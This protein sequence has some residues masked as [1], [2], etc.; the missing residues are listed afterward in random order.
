MLAFD[1]R[2]TTLLAIMHH[3]NT[4]P[5]NEAALQESAGVVMDQ[6]FT[7]VRAGCL[8]ECA[9][10][11]QI[12]TLSHGPDASPELHIHTCRKRCEETCRARAASPDP[13]YAAALAKAGYPSVTTGHFDDDESAAAMPAEGDDMKHSSVLTEVSA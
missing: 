7:Q 1:N 10:G 6:L 2:R 5:P 9:Y 8:H 12:S 13:A 4:P 3:P 11:P